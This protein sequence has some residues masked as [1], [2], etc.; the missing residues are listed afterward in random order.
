[1]MLCKADFEDL[2]P[3]LFPPEEK[4]AAPVP[5]KADRPDFLRAIGQKADA[6]RIPE[7]VNMRAPDPARPAYR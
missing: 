4:A 1:M 5:E 3:D 7:P 2:F 6:P